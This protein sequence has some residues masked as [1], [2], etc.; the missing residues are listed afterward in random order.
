MPKPKTVLYYNSQHQAK[1]AID[2][3]S[4][5]YIMLRSVTRHRV[6]M[7]LSIII[8]TSNETQN[9]YLWQ[10]LQ[11]LAPMVTPELEVIVVDSCSQDGTIERLQRH[12]IKL[13]QTKNA[14]RAARLNIGVAHAQGKALLLHHPRSIL[15]PDFIHNIHDF[16]VTNQH[17]FWGGFTLKHDHTHWLLRFVSWYSN[18]VRLKR[19]KTVY[20]D[21][22]IFIHAHLA[23]RVFPIPDVA[24]FEDTIL[25]QALA[26]HSPPILLPSI[27]VTSSIRFVTRGVIRQFLMNQCLKL[28]FTL[29]LPDGFMNRIYERHCQLNVIYRFFLRA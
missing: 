5:S 11:Q 26:K 14:N 23:R 27:A 6:I 8:P 25:S 10:S 2:F 15:S 16:T 4:K 13:I 9:Q 29:R 19:K 17:H 12:P 20:L 7:L 24:I 28:L 18:E 21:H 1:H 22:C 3:T